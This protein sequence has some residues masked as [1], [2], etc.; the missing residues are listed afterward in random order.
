MP[1]L[2]LMSTIVGLSILLPQTGFV[3]AH[4]IHTCNWR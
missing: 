1:F 3:S 2:S 4:I